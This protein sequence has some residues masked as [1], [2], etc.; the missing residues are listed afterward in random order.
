MPEY[1]R[2]SYGS[3]FGMQV[4]ANNLKT[5]MKWMTLYENIITTTDTRDRK[6]KQT[7]YH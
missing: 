4:S 3:I 7:G 6:F 2:E 5:W 1:V